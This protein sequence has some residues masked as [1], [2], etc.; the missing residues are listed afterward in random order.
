[1]AGSS[2]MPLDAAS[3]TIVRHLPD[4]SGSLGAKGL[5][6]RLLVAPEST[7]LRILT[8]GE[9]GLTMKIRHSTTAD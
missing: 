8:V 6:V 1:M 7:F 4:G 2:I 5:A 9:T 3:N